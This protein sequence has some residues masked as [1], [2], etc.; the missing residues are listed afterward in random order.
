MGSSKEK[1]DAIDKPLAYSETREESVHVGE[2][3]DSGDQLKRHLG[4]RQ[5]QLIAIGGSIG[6]ATFVS[7]SNGL[8]AG[9]PGSLFLAYTI[10]ACVMG[11]VNNCMAE[12]A[13]LQPVTGAFI[14]MAG[15]WVDESFGFMAGWNFFLYEALLIPFEI[16]ALTQVLSFWRDDI[17]V[18]AVIAVCLFLYL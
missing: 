2:I 18:A 4:N 11:L 7:I 12:M 1:G 17:P 6:T 9:G 3:T 8:V 13:V 10:Y 16:S 5:I 14:R 15:K